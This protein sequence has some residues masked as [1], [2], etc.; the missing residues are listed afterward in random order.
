MFR[1]VFGAALPLPDPPVDGCSIAVHVNSKEQIVGASSAC[2]AGGVHAF[3]WE[4]DGPMFDLNTL[5]SHGSGLQLTG[6]TSINERGE[7]TTFGVLSNGDTRAVLL[8]P[9]DKHHPS[10]E[11][12]NYTLVDEIP[13]TQISPVSRDVSTGAQRLFPPSRTSRFHIPGLATRPRI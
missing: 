2:G 1:E 3:L 8:I 6:V 7:I 10:V 9:C 11:G 12:C 5:V 13:V 4:N